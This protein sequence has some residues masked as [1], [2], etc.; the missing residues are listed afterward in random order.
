M[1]VTKLWL[2]GVAIE[3]VQAGDAIKDGSANYM[4]VD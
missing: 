4:G 2:R 3:Q 1:Q